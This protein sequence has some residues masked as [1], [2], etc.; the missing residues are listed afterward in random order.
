MNQAEQAKEEAERIEAAHADAMNGIEEERNRVLAGANQKAAA[1]YDRIVAQAKAQAAGI[2]KDAQAEAENR[3]QEILRQT[4]QEITQL[5][6][7]AT[8]K[9]VCNQ[10]DTD[11][12]I[13][14]LF[15]EK[16]GD[17]DGE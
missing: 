13:Y 4:Q 9:V 12:A 15:L 6:V 5:V 1:E 16:V 2:V 7:S 11:S 17:P 10:Q 14:D 3:K 8:E